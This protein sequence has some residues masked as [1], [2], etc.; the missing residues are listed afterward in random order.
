[1]GAGASHVSVSQPFQMVFVKGNIFWL[2]QI[3]GR[4]YPPPGDICV[5]QR[6]C[7]AMNGSYQVSNDLRNVHYQ[8][9]K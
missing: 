3:D 5:Q 6:V 9:E 7:T 2:C 4:H 1:M 8:H